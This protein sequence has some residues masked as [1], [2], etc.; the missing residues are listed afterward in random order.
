MRNRRRNAQATLEQFQAECIDLFGTPQAQI[1]EQLGI[2][3]IQALGVQMVQENSQ[4]RIKQLEKENADLKQQLSVVRE[5]EQEIEQL[6]H[7]IRD[8]EEKLSLVTNGQNWKKATDQRVLDSHMIAAEA[9]CYSVK[10]C[11]VNEI[12]SNL[13]NNGGIDVTARTVYR[14]LSVKEDTDLERVKTILHQFPEIFARHAVSEDEVLQW[15]STLRAKKLGFI[16][17]QKAMEQ[18]GIAILVGLQSDK[19]TVGKYYS[20]ADIEKRLAYYKKINKPEDK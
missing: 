14:A 20:M 11:S 3:D 4:N 13:W 15:F 6:R 2:D 8:L 17:E 18:Y 5:K 19:F 10:G 9:L 12:V 7:T 1:N 16:D